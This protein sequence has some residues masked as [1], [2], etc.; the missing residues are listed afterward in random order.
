VNIQANI[1]LSVL[2]LL[3]GHPTVVNQKDAVI[4]L[5]ATSATLAGFSLVF[6]GIVITRPANDKKLRS[7]FRIVAGWILIFW[8]D[9]LSA[10]CGLAWLYLSA[11]GAPTFLFLG[12][13]DLG[14]LYQSGWVLLWLTALVSYYVVIVTLRTVIR[15]DNK[16]ADVK[17]DT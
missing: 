5:V 14:F 1:S 17:D 2:A 4:A 7:E 12:N 6:L 10:G 13:I 11:P 16:A 9:L 8:L 15:R 3:S